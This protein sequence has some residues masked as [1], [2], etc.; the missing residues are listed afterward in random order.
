METLKAFEPF[1]VV[2]NVYILPSY[3][4][5]PSLGVLP[6]NAFLVRGAEPTLIDSGPGPLAAD[7]M[8]SLESLM[9]PAD[10]RWLWLTHTDPD[11]VGAVEWV[12]EAAP[13]ARVVTTFLGAGKMGLHRPLPEDRTHLIN[14]GE[15]LQIG[16][17]ELVALRPPSFDAPETIA[18]F[19]TSSRALFAA[20]CFGTLMSEPA[21]FASE[22]DD[23]ALREGMVTWAG[24][25]T[26]W[27]EHVTRDRFSLS[28]SQLERLEPSVVLSGHLPPAFDMHD[29]LSE[30]LLSAVGNGSQPVRDESAAEVLDAVF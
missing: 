17:R 16:D 19:D 23:A 3:C 4:P 22:I 5:L 20:D 11:H 8:D 30:H 27:L 2:K 10:L 13:R 18:A 28:T 26:P 1:E 29:R 7:L 15:R 25:D 6:M 24:I 14:P 9:D 12:L 21:A